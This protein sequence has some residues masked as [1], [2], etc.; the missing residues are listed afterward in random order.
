M[1]CAGLVDSVAHSSW[2]GLGFFGWEGRG[3]GEV[4]EGGRGGQ[5]VA[6]EE[7]VKWKR[8]REIRREVGGQ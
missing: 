4:I 7:E 6:E 3:G 5:R 2:V 8:T 1:F